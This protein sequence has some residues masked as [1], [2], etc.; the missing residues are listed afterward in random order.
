[1]DYDRKPSA[2]MRGANQDGITGHRGSGSSSSSRVVRYA[3]FQFKQHHNDGSDGSLQILDLK[4]PPA[5]AAALPAR[6]LYVQA[7]SSTAWLNGIDNLESTF[8]H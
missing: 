2:V 5:T 8:L 7:R 3:V 1:L 6:T 4:Q